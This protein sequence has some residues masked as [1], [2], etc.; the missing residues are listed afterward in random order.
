MV[1]V[2]LGLPL[3]FQKI[4]VLAPLAFTAVTIGEP[5]TMNGNGFPR[6]T[7]TMP[8]PPLSY[9]ELA[10]M[11]SDA[12]N[13][14]T[15]PYPL[16]PPRDA[17]LYATVLACPTRGVPVR[18]APITFCWIWLFVAVAP[19]IAM[20]SPTLPEMTFPWLAALFPMKFA[21]APS[22]STP[23]PWL[24]TTL[25]P[26]VSVP[27][28]LLYTM[29]PDALLP[30]MS[31]PVPLFPEI[32]FR[33]AGVP[34][35]V[36]LGTLLPVAVPVA[37][38]LMATPDPTLPDMTFPGGDPAGVAAP[39]T[40]L[41]FES[42]IA[43][44]CRPL[45]RGLSP[46]EVVPMRF[47]TK[48][49]PEE[50][51]EICT[52]SL[53]FAEMTLPGVGAAAV[54]VPPMVFVEAPNSSTPFSPF[55]RAAKP[56]KLVPIRLPRTLLPDEPVEICIPSSPFPEMTLPAPA[57]DPPMT[58]PVAAAPPLRAVMTT[59]F[60]VLPIAVLPLISVPM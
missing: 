16:A 54:G 45:A 23:L 29:F 58:L 3:N 17:P 53:A 18:G 57:T 47:P 5:G 19:E 37:A 7:S 9:I 12:P 38:P 27:M 4:S 55:A 52:P 11:E 20:P 25:V 59:P 2:V 35:I 34:P 24:A 15:T 21:A 8:R 22:I 10:R 60:W 49:L 44:P 14:T 28:K 43:T 26:V 50:P 48:V 33:E 6:L 13:G 31:T 42:N 51:D 46:A 56:V 40:V 32:T 41:L 39:P 36:L 30:E 1:Y